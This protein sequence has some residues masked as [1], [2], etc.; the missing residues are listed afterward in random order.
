CAPAVEKEMPRT[1]ARVKRALE[2]LRMCDDGYMLTRGP[3]ELPLAFGIKGD[4]VLLEVPGT[5]TGAEGDVT[6]HVGQ[7]KARHCY[8]ARDNADVARKLT[9]L[10]YQLIAIAES[11][12]RQEPIGWLEDLLHG[13]I[14]E[15]ITTPF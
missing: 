11:A 9:D 7:E 14:V 1:T 8:L 3:Y 4:S 5:L 6:P 13:D 12:S 10:F 2:L 15:Q